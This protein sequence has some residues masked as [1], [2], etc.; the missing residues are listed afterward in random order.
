VLLL[1][2]LAGYAGE[3]SQTAQWLSK[4]HR[5]VAFDARGHGHSE[6]APQDVS[7]AAHV[8][9]A[10]YVIEHFGLGPCT[11]IGHSLGGLTA[12]LL[13][14]DHPELVRTL[15][16]AE[17]MPA[18]PGMAAIADV[19]RSLARWPVPFETREAA[20]RFF[21]GSPPAD[22]P[23]AGTSAAAEIWADGL[24]QRDGGW[25]P[26]FDIPVMIRTLREAPP[27]SYWREW[28][29]IRRPTL[30]VRAGNGTLAAADARRMVEGL[31]G[32]RLAEIAGAGH[33]VHLDR[34]ADWQQTIEEFLASLE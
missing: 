12:L 27:G 28:E 11:V 7:R 30:I 16:V 9:D 4:H 13:A 22:S 14:A 5:V 31:P 26:R 20:A 24:E 34:P 32:S 17:A 6:R 33:D 21:A 19:E 29:R 8:A 23:L 2:G 1:Y 3:W 10:A 15:V 25:W 18:A